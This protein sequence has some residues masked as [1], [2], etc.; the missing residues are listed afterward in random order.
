ME[1]GTV[2]WFNNAKG[3]GFVT[4]ECGGDLFVHFNSIIGEGYRMLKQGESVT[5]DVEETQKGL[6]A[7]KVIQAPK[8]N[9]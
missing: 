9:K 1:K 2:K 3:F 5:F 4:R 8:Q 6:Q 7:I